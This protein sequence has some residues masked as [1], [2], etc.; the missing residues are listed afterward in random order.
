MSLTDRDICPTDV[1]M[2][3]S[4][5][6]GVLGKS[7]ILKDNNKFLFRLCSPFISGNFLF[8]KMETG[9]EVLPG[10][11]GI[12][13]NTLFYVELKRFE[14]CIFF[15]LLSFRRGTPENF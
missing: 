13:L 12:V 6:F 3:A 9:F 4:T 11:L 1:G 15:F 8:R 5:A 14:F 10:K 7:I 2:I